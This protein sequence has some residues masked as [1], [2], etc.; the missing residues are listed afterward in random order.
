[1]F[2]LAVFNPSFLTIMG[3]KGKL[4][5]HIREKDMEKVTGHLAQ[6]YDPVG[7]QLLYSSTAYLNLQ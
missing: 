5:P 1:M 6:M 4:G 3:K 2:A 7:Q